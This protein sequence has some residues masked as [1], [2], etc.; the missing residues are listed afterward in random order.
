MMAG[1]NNYRDK[2]IA[3]VDR[4]VGDEILAT[5]QTDVLP[6][7]GQPVDVAGEQWTVYDVQQVTQD[8]VYDGLIFLEKRRS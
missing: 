1:M 7:R 2:T 5:E 6:R 3:Y 8:T 4:E